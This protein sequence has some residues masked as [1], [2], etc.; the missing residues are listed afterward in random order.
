M[1]TKYRGISGNLLVYDETIVC[2][3]CQTEYEQGELH[4]C[5]DVQKS[6][7][8]FDFTGAI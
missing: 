2:P 1:N 4:I 6:D 8:D 3:H 7:H 5:P